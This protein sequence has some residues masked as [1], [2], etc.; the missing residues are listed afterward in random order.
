ML[1]LLDH[2]NRVQIPLLLL[3][4]FT[5]KILLIVSCRKIIETPY[6][7]SYGLNNIPAAF[8]QELLWY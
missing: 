1:K 7:S 2:P 6:P 3:N 5:I 8:L 4:L